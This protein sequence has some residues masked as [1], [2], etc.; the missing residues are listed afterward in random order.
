MKRFSKGLLA[1]LAFLLVAGS[2][3]AQT[4]IC[5]QSATGHGC[6]PVSA[7]APLP[8]TGS[9]SASSTA[10]A[11]STLPSLSAGS[12]KAIYESLSGGQFSQLIDGSTIVSG[13]HGLPVNIVAGG[14]TGAVYGPTANGSPAANPP[15]LMGGTATGGA[16]G[17]VANATILPGNSA[18]TPLPAVVVADPNV[19][20]GINAPPNLYNSGGNI[21]W[22]GST[23]GGLNYGLTHVDPAQVVTTGTAGSPSTQVVSVQGVASGT[24][25]PV[26]PAA[27]QNSLG[28]FGSL[29]KRVCVTPT[30]TNG[31]YG[32]NVV[33]GG[34]LTF[35]NLFTSTGSGAIQSVSV[36]FTTA[37]TV[38]FTLFPFAGSPTNASTW[39]DH[40]AA[41]ISGSAD[42]FL[43]SPPISL[44]ASN[45]SLGTMTNYSIS[46][47]GQSYSTGGTSGYFILVPNATTAS[48]GAT[49]NAVSVCVTV[50]QDS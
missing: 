27:T 6:T 48:L 1:G 33:V 49:S 46:G 23:I 45:S 24:P 12:G 5:F 8:V 13:S 15:I 39:T 36:N 44:T 7:A 41:A 20:A 3:Q 42:I 16:T 26:T 18:T 11:Q 34:L 30:V 28:N 35:S 22:G 31:T 25:V 37:Q 2:A 43:T 40:S 10:T 29:T 32:A 14:G 47:L 50:L 17:N 9:F 38:G 4:L 21:A 19:L